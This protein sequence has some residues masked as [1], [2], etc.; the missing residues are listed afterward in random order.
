MEED[1]TTLLEQAVA[2]LQAE[3]VETQ[4][5]LQ[6]ILATMQ[7]TNQTSQQQQQQQQQQ[8]PPKAAPQEVNE[9]RRSAPPPEFDGEHA[10][11]KFLPNILQTLPRRIPG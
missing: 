1:R 2:K 8:E 3:R 9:P 10:I 4:N 11:P 5:L 7:Q 6:Q